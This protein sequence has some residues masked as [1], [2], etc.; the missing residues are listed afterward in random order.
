MA[1]RTLVI[2]NPQSGNRKTGRRWPSV[3]PGLRAAL[4]ALDVEY[5]RAPRDAER[6]AREAVRSGVERLVVAG[7]DGTLKEVV[8]GLLSTDL[9]DR[10]EIGV[11]PFGTGGDFARAF[12]APRRIDAAIAALEDGKTR[13]IDAGKI[14]YR[15]SQD[16]EVTSYFANV[17]SLGISGLVD[18]FVARSPRPFGGRMAFLAAS[19][20]ALSA[21]RSEVVAISVDDEEVFEGPLALAVAAN[22]SYFGGGMHIAPA[23]RLD[24][25][26]L[27]VV[28]I[29]AASNLRLATKLPQ[30]YRGTHVRDPLTT[31]LQGRVIEAHVAPGRVHIDVDGEPLGTAPV[32]IEALPGA[33]TFF[34]AAS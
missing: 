3:E 21:Y 1:V 5:T 15:D 23:A 7:G 18:L 29:S 11:L 28:I 19:L 25:G 14:Q 34:G 33:I 31:V 22:G 9:A 20:R 26:L 6:I 8:S 30:L 4:G 13:T 16:R 27:E 10:I 12:G 17:A 24:D 32:R 2:V